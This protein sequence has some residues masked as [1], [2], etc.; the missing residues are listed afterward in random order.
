MPSVTFGSSSQLKL[1]RVVPTRGENR[2][3]ILSS[4]FATDICAYAVMSNLLHIVVKLCPTSLNELTDEDIV[5]RWTSL[6]AGPLLLQKWQKGEPLKAAELQV[7]K[8]CIAIYRKRLADIGWF[9]KC[10][11]EPIARQANREDRCTGH[12]YK[13]HP[14]VLPFGSP[15]GDQKYS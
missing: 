5:E 10:L 4:I 8:D 2:I 12:Y 7:V 11:N 9:M 6:F 14:C 13:T 15:K 3:R 1:C